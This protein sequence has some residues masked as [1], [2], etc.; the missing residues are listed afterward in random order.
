MYGDALCSC[1]RQQTPIRAKENRRKSLGHKQE[2]KLKG[3]Q[4]SEPVPKDKWPGATAS[5]SPVC[6]SLDVRYVFGPSRCKGIGTDDLGR[7]PL[8]VNR[9]MDRPR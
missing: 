9:L 1:G 4:S 6:H 7:Q 3:V 2:G 5:V 8:S